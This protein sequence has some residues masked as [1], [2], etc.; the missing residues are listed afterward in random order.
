MLQLARLRRFFVTPTFVLTVALSAP[1]QE[2]P[3]QDLG[4]SGLL[5]ALAKLKTTAR[6]LHSTAH[7][8]DD[9]GSMLVYESRAEGATTLM[10]TLNR[11]EGGQNKIGSELFD[12]L[13]LLR[14]LELTEADRYYGVEQRF[15]RVVDFGF[16][17]SSAETFEK[18]GGHEAALADMVRVSREFRPDVIVC[19]FVGDERDGHGNHQ[20]AG[21]LS[22]EAF[23]AAADPSRFPEQI[24]EGLLPWQVK[25]LYTGNVRGSDDITL[26]LDTGAYSPVLGMSYAQFAIEGL[27]HQMSQGVGGWTA[28]PGRNFRNYK[29]LESVLPM[30]PGQEKSFFDG[31]DTSVPGLATRLGGEANKATFLRPALAAIERSVNEASAAFDARDPS[32]TA[33]A[34]LAGLAQVRML[35]RQV[36]SSQLSPAAKAEL[37]THLETKRQQFEE[38]V[39]L[40]LATELAVAV[41]SG[42]NRSPLPQFF[43]QEQT[44]LYAVPG[45]TFTVTARF[46]NRS[47]Q[48]IVPRQIELLLP[49]GWKSE[50]LKSDLKP[51]AGNEGAS[52]QFR[53]TVPAD[54]QYTRPYWRRDEQTQ[55]VYQILR[56]EYA[57]LPLP[58][59]PVQARA[60]FS[61]AGR[62]EEASIRSVAQVKFIDPLFGQMQRPLPVAP[63]V[64]VEMDWPVQVAPIRP[65][66]SFE[67]AVNVR[68]N[69]SAAGSA[70]VR[71]EA[72][73]GW[74]VE[75]AA[76]PVEFAAEGEH[77][78]VRFRL[79]PPS[80]REGFY[81]VSASAEQQGRRYAEGFRTIGRSDVGFFYSYKPARQKISAV[82]V[83]LPSNLRVGYIMGA[84]DDIPSVLRQLGIPVTMITADQLASGDLTRFDTI[85]VGIR[86]YDV[87]SDIREHNQRLLDFV[88][89]GGTLVVQYNASTGQFNAGHYT[90]YHA[91]V[92]NERVTEEEAPVEILAPQHPVLNFPNRISARDFQGWV[93]ERGLYFMGQWDPQYTPLLASHDSGE[94]PLKGGLLVAPYGKGMYVFTGYAF[95]RQLPAG[96]P[97][98]IRLFVNLLSAHRAS[99]GE[100]PGR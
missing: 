97:G 70:T 19:R 71:L 53:I 24:R 75:P 33:P 77:K 54:A 100:A 13:G 94:Q 80:L 58:P 95:F 1:A 52:A 23:H 67:V 44:F 56:P 57:T 8:D 89:R 15:T 3:A 66:A 38:A 62:D 60:T 30:P 50:L 4:S 78:T 35:L 87:R 73:Q 81:S 22:R 45:Q 51:L 96:V 6:L 74:Q 25:K 59:W 49:A 48:N 82:D 63:P 86:A 65:Q 42:E 20:A 55:N 98:A 40:A 34:L 9:D 39:N 31:I 92:A 47:R 29:L 16:S 72:P 7:P 14:T 69:A 41:D 76:A 12:D 32:R 18:W 61:L 90:P 85:V 36:E 64:S 93:Q 5:Q 21:I 26:R 83:A 79:Q 37:T 2:I 11:G 88:S 28:P 99:D 84:G 46:Y 10:L 17:K 91:S 27:K 68:N 43:R